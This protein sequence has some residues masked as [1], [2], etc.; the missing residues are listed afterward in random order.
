MRTPADL[1]PY[2][3]R[4]VT[5]LYEHD[6]VGVRVPMGGGKTAVMLTALAE[7]LRD[8]AIRAAVVVAPKRVAQ[9]VWSKEHRLWSHLQHMR[10]QVVDGG[11]GARLEKLLDGAHDIYVVGVDNAQ[12]LVGELLKLPASHPLYDAL[13]IDELSRLRNPRGKRGRALM[14]VARRFKNIYGLTGTP[15]PNGFE[16]LY[17]PMQLLSRGS[18][19]GSSFYKWREE[20]FMSLDFMGYS[21]SIRPEWRDRTLADIAPYWVS[22]ADDEMPELPEIVSVVHAVALPKA[23]AEEYKRMERSLL[24]KFPDRAVLAANAAVA[25]GKL[26]QLVQGFM[27]DETGGVQHVHTAKADLLVDLIEDLAGDPVLVA[28]EFQEDLRLLLEL[29]PGTP[30]L[31]AGVS[32]AA[33]ARHEAAWNRGELPI[34][35]LHPASAGHGLNLQHGG[36]QFIWYGLTW[37]A[38]LFDQT[39]KRYHRPGQTRRCFEHFIHAPGTTDDVKYARV[40]EKMNMQDAFTKHLRSV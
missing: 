5:H 30:Y 13:V 16:D 21:W 39:R 4:L 19:W 34:L 7:L 15:R 12:W 35:L 18:L 1:R 29:Y 3:Q 26:C 20:R 27:Y 36:S 22:V 17:R 40:V 2:Q 31:G 37:S 8:G 14:R 32:D 9:L 24:A 25:T 23:A 33:A 11:P 6:S 10:V 38:E 28:Y